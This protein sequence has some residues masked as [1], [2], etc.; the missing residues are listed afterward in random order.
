MTILGLF[1]TQGPTYT[2]TFTTMVSMKILLWA[3]SLTIG[4]MAHP[5]QD[6]IAIEPSFDFGGFNETSQQHYGHVH[7]RVLVKCS[8]TDLVTLARAYGQAKQMVRVIN[9]NVLAL[10]HR[11]LLM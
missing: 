2:N 4:M 1:T 9:S 7:K 8:S 11:L 3:S 5:V 10:M 6:T